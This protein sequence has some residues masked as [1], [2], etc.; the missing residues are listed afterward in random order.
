MTYSRPLF[1]SPPARPKRQN[2]AG[3]TT[4]TI[5]V[6]AKVQPETWTIQFTASPGS[7]A[8][9]VCRI[10]KVLKNAWRCYHLKACVVAGPGT[11]STPELLTTPKPPEASAGP[12]I[13]VCASP[14]KGGTD[15]QQH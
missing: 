10:R 14:Q 4:P 2:R 11:D 15:K 13:G 3:S 5:P 1:D 9:P 6:P 12:E 7:N 8:P